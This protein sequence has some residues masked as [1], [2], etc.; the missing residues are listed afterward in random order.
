M[1][2]FFYEIEQIQMVK[3]PAGTETFFIW[4]LSGRASLQ[5]GGGQLRARQHRQDANE[6][7]RAGHRHGP[8]FQ[9]PVQS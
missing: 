8:A 9:P 5:W 4:M 1:T 3:L 6:A 7:G 2:S